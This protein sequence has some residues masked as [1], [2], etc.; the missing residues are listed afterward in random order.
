MDGE[1][2]KLNFNSYVAGKV[3]PLTMDNALAM[4]QIGG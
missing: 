4:S 1:S 2:A 3:P